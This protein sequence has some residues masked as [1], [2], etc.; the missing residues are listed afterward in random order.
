M[1]QVRKGFEFNYHKW[2]HKMVRERPEVKTLKPQIFPK[3]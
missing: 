3:G 1:G 2:W